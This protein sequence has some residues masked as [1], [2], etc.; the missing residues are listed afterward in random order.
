MSG[1][2]LL[3]KDQI[4]Q[5]SDRQIIRIEC[6][7]WGGD[8]CI[9][10][11]TGAQRDEVEQ[12]LVTDDRIGYRAWVVAHALCDAEGDSLGFDAYDINELTKKSA[13][14]I[15]RI[16]NR[17]HELSFLSGGEE[18]VAEAEKNSPNGQSGDSG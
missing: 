7:E 1:N 6:P 13:K 8:V 9:R 16:F 10:P 15:D 12:R 3:T 11:L 18:V 4:L 2:G 14:P 17:V 5:A